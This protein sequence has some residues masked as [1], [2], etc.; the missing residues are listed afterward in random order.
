MSL[1]I[2]NPALCDHSTCHVSSPYLLKIKL[3]PDDSTSLTWSPFRKTRLL[4]FQECCIGICNSPI[5]KVQSQWTKEIK[6]WL[7]RA[8]HQVYLR[9][10]PVWLCPICIA[11]LSIKCQYE[12]WIIVSLEKFYIADE[13]HNTMCWWVIM[14]TSNLEH[15]LTWHIHVIPSTD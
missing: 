10:C 15:L 12:N 14:D 1:Q 5:K 4:E 8:C 13:L 9:V 2:V 7:W 11:G 6:A 3:I